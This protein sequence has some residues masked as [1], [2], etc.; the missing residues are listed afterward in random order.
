MSYSPRPY[1]LQVA[2]DAGLQLD[3]GVD[4]L[5]VVA[6]TGTG[7]TVIGTNMIG[8]R[9]QSRHLWLAHRRELV[10]QASRK[11]AECGISAGIIMAGVYPNLHHGVQV[12]SIDTLRAW[13][14]KSTM[15]LPPADYVWA[16]E[17]HRSMSPKFREVLNEYLKS[18]AK[19]IGLTA[20]PIRADGHGLGRFYQQLVQTPGAAWMVANGYLVPMRYAVPFVP[21]LDG[22]K[23][24]HGDYDK[25][26]IAEIMDQ[27]H[28]VGDVV[29]NWLRLA[30][31]RKTFVFASGVAHSIHLCERFQEVGINAAHIDGHTETAKRDRILDAFNR[32]DIQVL[33][34]DSVFVEGTD[35]PSANCIVAARPTRSLGRY[36]Q[37]NR[38]GRLAPGK[39]DC[40]WLDHCGAYYTFGRHDRDIE[41]TLGMGRKEQAKKMAEQRQGERIEFTCRECHRVFS[42]RVV[43]PDCG[44]KIERVGRFREYLDGEL[45]ELT[46][47]EYDAHKPGTLE[48]AHFYLQLRSIAQREGKESWWPRKFYE[49]KYGEKPE[50]RLDTFTLREPTTETLGWVKN[51]RIRYAHRTGKRKAKGEAKAS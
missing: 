1:Q 16:D 22:V 44:T 37:M 18:G 34:N 50:R 32:G 29:E 46:N 28:L 21:N 27:K 12:A 45:C 4:R 35:V 8:E 33:T 39:V 2:A 42:G 26:Q 19:V 51:Q 17:A 41:W 25:Q 9:Q 6:P 23:V 11:L 13:V 43:C 47:G 20:T 24:K 14:G 15:Q 49:L 30:R 3:M 7:K 36:L 31:D 5:L 10:H 38:G 40:L 48:K